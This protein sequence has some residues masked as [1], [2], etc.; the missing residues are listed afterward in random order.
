MVL[1]LNDDSTLFAVLESFGN[2]KNNQEKNINNEMKL[3][4]SWFQANRLSINGLKTKAMIFHNTQKKIDKLRL[5]IDDSYI[6]IVDEFNYLG[7]FF[8]KN[9]KWSTHINYVAK[10]VSRNIGIM[11]RLK[12]L[13]P[14]HILL[15][16]YNSLIYPY[17]NY[18]IIVWGVNTNKLKKLQKKAIRILTNAKYNAHTEPLFKELNILKIG[19][20][21]KLQELKFLYKLENRTLPNYFQQNFFTRQSDI[22]DY[23]TRFTSNYRNPLTRHVFT[24]KSIRNRIPDIY[25]KCPQ[26]IKG[27]LTTHS[28]SG[29]S[30]YVKYTLVMNYSN[31]C[32]VPDCYICNFVG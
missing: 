32:N 14:R 23:N 6:D 18:G 26:N 25:N 9:L 30:K 17:M 5:Q 2:N 3:I 16:L 21:M 13:L 24:H 28:Y 1:S 19:D 29:F 15:T 20:M 27:K 12:R 4:N 7:I 31:I 8:D 22:H 11:A 10:K